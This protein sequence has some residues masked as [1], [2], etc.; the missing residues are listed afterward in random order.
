[1]YEYL[2]TLYAGL[3][4]A[5]FDTTFDESPTRCRFVFLLTIHPHI[6]AMLACIKS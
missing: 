6:S 5:Y 4:P 3:V 2:I 1:M